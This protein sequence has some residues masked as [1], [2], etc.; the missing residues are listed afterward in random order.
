MPP[1]SASDAALE[2]FNVIRR[3]WRVVAG[4]AGF[5]LLALIMMVVLTVVLLLALTVASGGGLQ[6]TP[7][8]TSGALGGAVGALGTLFAQAIVV[9][10]LYRLILRP[11]EPAFL[12]LR[13]GRDELRLVGLW[14]IWIIAL[15]VLAGV[16][17]VVGQAAG[18]R[19]GALA[20]VV[21][22]VVVIYLTLRFCLVAPISYVEH[23]IDFATSW[24][25]TR[26]R[27]VALLGMAILSACLIALVMIAASIVLLGVVGLVT[28]FQG[29]L[30]VTAD[31]AA[32]ET[33]PGVYLLNMVADILFAPVLWVLSQAPLAAAYRALSGTQEV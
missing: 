31:A 29:I 2:G 11:Q 19:A 26:G 33:H 9:G 5:N 14:V 6:G 22:L 21:G 16:I 18:G 15:V 13:L 27:A 12:H 7:S 23:R 32:F 30:A 4:W 24:R 3:H 28:G 17:D 20:G 10:G 8:A 1:F 25:L